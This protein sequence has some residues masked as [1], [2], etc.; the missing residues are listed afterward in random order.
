MQIIKENLDDKKQSK[1]VDEFINDL[2][3]NWEWV[4][5]VFH[6]DMQKLF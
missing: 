1:I 5:L 4:N 3:K 2:S 6:P